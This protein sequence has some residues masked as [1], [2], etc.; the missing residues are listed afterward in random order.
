MTSSFVDMRLSLNL[1]SDSLS[2]TK[3]VRQCDCAISRADL[4]ARWPSTLSSASTSVARTSPAASLGPA[5][6]LTRRIRYAT[7]A[8]LLSRVL[9]VDDDE[10]IG[11]S[12]PA[13]W[14]MPATRS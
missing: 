9:V 13:R 4:I 3:M 2:P 10:G 8:Q 14:D 7:M 1:Y 6:R 11:A 12:L 5:R